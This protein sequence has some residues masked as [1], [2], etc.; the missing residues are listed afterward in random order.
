M[1][2]RMN[3]HAASVLLRQVWVSA[4]F[5]LLLA[6]LI[7]IL[8]WQERRREWLLH[9]ND[10]TH[11]TEFAF[12]RINSELQSVKADLLFL[13]DERSVKGFVQG[14][15]RHRQALT[16]TF[17]SFVH[18]KKN[19]DQIR[20]LN[21]NGHETIRVNYIDGAAVSVPESDLQDKSDRYYFAES[22]GLRLENVFVSDFDLNLEHGRVEKPLKP[23]IRF[24]TPVGS[25]DENGRGYL[26]LNYLGAKLLSEVDRPAGVGQLWL[27]RSDGHYVRGPRESDDWG[28]V[29]RHERTFYQQFPNEWSKIDEMTRGSMT[30]QGLFLSKRISL[31]EP[32]PDASI[33]SRSKPRDSLILVSHVPSSE[34]F[35]SSRKGLRHQLVLAC[36][37]L[38]PVLV[39]IRYWASSRVARQFQ[40]RLIA[41]SEEKLRELSARLL[42][43]Q[44]DERRAISREI[45]DDLGQQVNCHRVGPET[46]RAKTGKLDQRAFGK[47]HQGQRTVATILACLCNTS[48]SRCPG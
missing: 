41:Q 27:L 20:L 39:V 24:V 16:A 26:V 33:S 17:S 30:A 12:E 40:A 1:T 7:A 3:P 11:R 5:V 23:V 29:L 35:A 42:R 9:L 14:E 38:L 28:W 18:R 31:G 21:A 10:I 47:S 44:E 13:A 19:Y 45:H 4:A 6:L 8:F 32:S 37:C 34:L 22:K 2:R 36:F 25:A 46:R 15:K 43:I 48:S